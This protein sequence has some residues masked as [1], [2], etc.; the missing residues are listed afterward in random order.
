MTADVDAPAAGDPDRGPRPPAVMTVDLD[1]RTVAWTLALLAAL[2]AVVAGLRTAS[3][4]LTVLLVAVFVALALDPVVTAL[5]RRGISRGWATVLTL[6]GLTL[7]VV[8]FGLLAGP[9]LAEQSRR[10][11]VDLPRT[12]RSMEDLPF[13][14]P[15]LARA[16][17]A[18]KV[19][20]FLSSLP[21]KLATE[22]ADLSSLAR[23]VGVGLGVVVI[24]LLVTAGV[25]FEGPGLVRLVRSALPA[26]RRTGA[27]ALGRIVYRVLARYFAGSLLIAA[28]NGVWVAGWALVAGVPLSPVL[29]V[30]AALTSLIPQIGGLLGFVL[31]LAVSLAAGLVPALVMTAAFAVL[32]VAT[33]HLLQPTIVGRAVRLS[34]P[35]T[36]V[37]AIAGLAVAGIVGALVAVPGAGV[38]KAVVLHAQGRDPDDS[39]DESPGLLQ[40]WRAHRAARHAAV[41]TAG[42]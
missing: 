24:H 9:Q 15:S 23:G 10:L 18:S 27:D 5:Q 16:D 34:A 29:G 36:M 4:T 2:A 8:G 31:V 19:S 30:W 17:V 32:L 41:T 12:A 3:D 25:L 14:G 7:L 42:G 1:W 21:Q 26:S 38:V 35:A 28:I 11:G 20:E 40:R 33:N 6:T 22:G 13:V 39:A 37:A